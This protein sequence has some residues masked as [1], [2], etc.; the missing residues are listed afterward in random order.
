MAQSSQSPWQGRGNELNSHFSN[1]QQTSGLLPSPALELNSQLLKLSLFNKD[2]SRLGRVLD[3]VILT[4]HF[5]TK[6]H[7]TTLKSGNATIC[8]A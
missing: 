8:A 4:D 5:S 7:V 2:F 3:D 1:R 6:L